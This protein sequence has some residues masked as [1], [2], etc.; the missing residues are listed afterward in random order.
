MATRSFR[1]AAGPE[2]SRAPVMQ[3]PAQAAQAAQGRRGIEQAQA[4]GTPET[5]P[6]PA[7][8]LGTGVRTQRD[9]YQGYQ[10]Y[11]GYDAQRQML[12]AQQA[13]RVIPGMKR[14]GVVKGRGDGIARRGH[15]KGTLR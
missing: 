15:T 8:P 5:R 10:P 2:G 11:E 13:A 12:E 9:W 3:T 14:G 1:R 6:V 7:A 4:M